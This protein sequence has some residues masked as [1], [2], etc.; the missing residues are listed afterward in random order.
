MEIKNFGVGT[1]VSSFILIVSIIIDFCI[2]YK[3]YVHLT[4]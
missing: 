3:L 2:T 4:S 1:E